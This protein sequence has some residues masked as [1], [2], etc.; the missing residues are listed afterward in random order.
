MLSFPSITKDQ[1]C[2]ASHILTEKGIRAGNTTA[3]ASR[4][5][6][7]H[8]VGFWGSHRSP[9]YL[10]IAG[11]S[12][13]PKNWFTCWNGIGALVVF[14]NE[15]FHLLSSPPTCFWARVFLGVS[16]E[17]KYAFSSSALTLRSTEELG[18]NQNRVQGLVLA[19]SHSS[20]RRHWREI[21]VDRWIERKPA[22]K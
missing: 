7:N 1:F 18:M 13:Q 17:F 2:K 22:Q 3:T 4:D 8:S 15:L 11:P 6:R 20:L 14:I 9:H 5:P 12:L 16:E 10:V 21:P 19:L